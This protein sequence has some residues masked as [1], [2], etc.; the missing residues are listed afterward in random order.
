MSCTLIALF[1][2]IMALLAGV[3]LRALAQDLE[4]TAAEPMNDAGLDAASPDVDATF[5]DVTPAPPEVV[6][7]RTSEQ[8]PVPEPVTPAPLPPTPEQ[9]TTPASVL[10]PPPPPPPP[11]R[12]SP[13]YTV[14]SFTR[15][16]LRHGYDDLGIAR[17]RFQEGDAFFYRTRFG[18][19]TG[20]LALGEGLAA[21]V[22]ITPQAAGTFGENASTIA[23][24]RLGLHEGYAR[25]QGK[26]IRFDAG[27]YEMVYGDALMI[28]NNDWNEV[29]RTFDGLRARIGDQAWLDLFANV[30]DEGRPDFPGTGD[31][32]LYFL[33]AYGSLG[34]LAHAYFTAITELDLYLL[35][36]VWGVVKDAQM[37]REG[38]R[39][40]TLGAR[41]KGRVGACD[42]R[43]EAGMQAGTRP[44]IV[45]SVRALA[46]QGDVELGVALF[47]ERLR[48][49]FEALYASGAN[50]R[51]GERS[52]GWEDLYPSGHKWLGLAD[53]F[54]QNGQKRTN[55]ASAVLHATGRLL[56]KLTVQ[57]DA[58][59][60]ARPQPS[61][62]GA[63]RGFAGGE[64]DAGLLYAVAKGL[65][66]RVLYALFLPD[67]RLY[68]DV[69]P[70]RMR[71][72]DPD[73]AQYFE[74]ELRYDL[75][76][77]M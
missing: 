36:R 40:L 67:R 55:V 11:P 68:N 38:A 42:Y 18:F 43:A 8:P 77:S 45:E 58:H 62:L 34:S 66:V 51:D 49:S 41:G 72:R 6:P 70:D 32:D 12:W 46:W 9:L 1:A 26:R 23:D 28:G 44:G 22:Q 52:H 37:R 31:G 14:S 33:G 74:A 59:A 61:V 71:W 30:I 20:L 7:A 16:E 15:Y 56:E 2:L 63:E 39:E 5:T 75:G 10:A 4:P 19:N 27:R 35:A 65:K 13:T 29:G 69:V 17:G 54:N 64:L 24:A 73:P 57:L 47:G 76:G 21:A 25:L 50:P 53:A 48:L 60:F 3:P